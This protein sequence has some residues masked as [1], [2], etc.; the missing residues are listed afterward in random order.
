[1][2][3]L[4]AAVSFAVLLP[5]T[6]WSG[7]VSLAW[8]AMSMCSFVIAELLIAPLGLSPCSAAFPNDLWGSHRPLVQRG[9]LRLLRRWRNWRTVVTLADAASA[10]SYHCCPLRSCAA[11]ESPHTIPMRARLPQES[12]ME[13]RTQESAHSTCSGL[14]AL[15]FSSHKTDHSDREAALSPARATSGNSLWESKS[16]FTEQ[17]RELRIAWPVA[18]AQ[19]Q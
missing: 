17:L 12:R 18:H 4:A 13:S 8:L 7:R 5:T 14:P 1:M 2:G 6:Q 3:L 16:C 9:S 15:A 10:H 19:R 11:M